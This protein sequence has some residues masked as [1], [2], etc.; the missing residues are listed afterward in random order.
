MLFN[1]LDFAIFLPSVFILYWFVFKR[2][3]KLQNVLLILASYVFYGWWDYRFLALIIFSSLVDYAIGKKL[4]NEEEPIKR[5]I[6]LW[7]SILV[8]LGFLGF[9]KY[10]NFFIDNF[11]EAFSFFGNKIQPNTLDIILPVGI[12]FYTFQTLSYTIDVYK[13]KLEPTDD[14]ISFLAFVSFFPQLVAGPIERAT[15]LLPQFYIK[16]VFHFSAATD[17]C[18]QIL[19]GLF[20]KIVIAD[21]CAVYANTIFNN[22]D[23]YS[24]STLFVG[25]IFFAFQIYGDFSGYSD[26]A[27]GT[28]RLFGFSLKQNFA[29]PY[30]SR[31][32]AEFWR[33]WHISLSTWFRDYLYIPLGGS[34]VGTWKKIRNIFIIFIVSGFWHGANWTFIFWGFLN[35]LYFLP[36]LIRKQNRNNLNIIAQNQNLPTFKEVFQMAITFCLT[37]LA[38]VFFRAENMAHAWDYIKGIF[39]FSFLSLPEVRPTN[40]LV[41]LVFFIIVE[42]IGRCQ[43]YA[44]EVLLL[45]KPRLLKWIFY[46]FLMALIFIFSGESQQTFIY[47]QF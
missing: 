4:R 2:N 11:V 25:A 19:W 23:S 13:K 24:G 36:L 31:D 46:S 30:F 7:I 3:I 8:N 22:S 29:F 42:W 17:G 34:Q 21:Q 38:W 6:L 35:A 12:S 14:V 45:K 18:R 33:R 26:I 15:N 10:Y 37:T 39:S 41:L 32:I 43:H 28:S 1:S 47:F 20:K 5:K 44:I 40:L 16:R 27:I 9:F